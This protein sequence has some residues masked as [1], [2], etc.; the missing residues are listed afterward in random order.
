MMVM[1]QRLDLMIL[2]VFSN[3]YDS[4]NRSVPSGSTQLV[5]SPA[6]EGMLCNGGA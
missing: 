1:G 2:V 6:S 5:C 4:V 3:L